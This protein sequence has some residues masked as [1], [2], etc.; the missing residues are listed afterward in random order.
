[1][2]DSG[3]SPRGKGNKK[4]LHLL[5]A[6]TPTSLCSTV[7]WYTR[8]DVMLV[9]PATLRHIVCEPIINS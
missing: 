8:R 7:N 1:M 5:G 9:T 3:M 6:S 4:F 2:D